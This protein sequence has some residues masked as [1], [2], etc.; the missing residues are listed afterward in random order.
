[1]AAQ[2]NSS[3]SHTVTDDYSSSDVIMCFHQFYV[4]NR[5]CI[6]S[7]HVEQMKL[8]HMLLMIIVVLIIT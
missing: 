5:S 6:Q 3:I 2:I 4:L 7:S 8:V 1:M